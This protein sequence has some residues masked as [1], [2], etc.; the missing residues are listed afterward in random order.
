MTKGQMFGVNKETNKLRFEL[1]ATPGDLAPFIYF[2]IV[3]SQGA[4]NGIIN[5]TL[6]A[7][8]QISS[9]ATAASER[10]VVAN[11][12]IPFANIQNLKEAIDSVLL[13]GTPM[14]SGASS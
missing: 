7:V 8:R 13:M 3:G 11:L 2:D 14:P 1:A 9:G 4:G 12:T 6:E 10:V 5:M